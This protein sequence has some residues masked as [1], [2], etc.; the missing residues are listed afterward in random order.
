MKVEKLKTWLEN[1][2]LPEKQFIFEDNRNIIKRLDDSC[3]FHKGL[4]EYK[5]NDQFYG[6][7]SKF[8][9]DLRTVTLTL[10]KKDTDSFVSHFNFDIN[11]LEEMLID[12]ETIL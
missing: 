5:F 4:L 10:H 11:R 7:I 9:S 3:I 6:I 12:I 8:H 2:E 1:K